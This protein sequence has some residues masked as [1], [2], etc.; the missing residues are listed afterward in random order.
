MGHQRSPF[1]FILILSQQKNKGEKTIHQVS[2][3]KIRTQNLSN[4]SHIP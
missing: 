2:D 4:I 1:K 3:A